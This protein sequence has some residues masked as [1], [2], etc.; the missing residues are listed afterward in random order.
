MPIR[1][2]IKWILI[3]GM[4]FN[5]TSI[6][7]ADKLI[8]ALSKHHESGAQLWVDNCARCHNYRSPTEFTPN[9]WKTIM[10]HMRFQAGLT[11]EEAK[12][13]LDYLT[14][15][16]IAEF[17]TTPVTKPQI[18]KVSGQ[19]IP[20]SGKT[21]YETT[22]IG[23]HG[24]NGKGNGPSFPD[25]TRKN[26]VLSKPNNVLLNNVIHGIGGMPPKGGN[27]SLT[28]DDLQAALNYIKDTFG[29]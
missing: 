24:A 22:C 25:F 5:Q 15:S 23:C 14:Q 7:Y 11:C 21:I 9:Q 3:F 29:H 20:A 8:S 27:P 2:S 26:G 18:N 4:I 6:C 12:E 28:N 16:S 1:F 19:H 17:Q 13:V 10:L